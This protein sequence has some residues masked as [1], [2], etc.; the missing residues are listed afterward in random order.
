[1]D[2]TT[3]LYQSIYLEAD[4]SA[5]IIERIMPKTDDTK[6]LWTLESHIR[7][8]E[9]IKNSA[10]KNL[11]KHHYPPRIVPASKRLK[12]ETTVSIKTIGNKSSE[13]LAKI[14]ANQKNEMIHTSTQKQRKLKK[15][16]EESKK[17]MDFFIETEKNHLKQYE[18]FLST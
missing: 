14:L 13:N 10:E 12:Q 3:E 1:M 5:S 4:L 15:A 18:N 2:H 17:T 11:Y 9:R 7:D 8:Y 16:D 6:L